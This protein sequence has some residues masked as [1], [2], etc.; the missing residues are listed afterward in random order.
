MKGLDV[1]VGGLEG[2]LSLSHRELEAGVHSDV[3]AVVVDFDLGR[4]VLAGHQHR[5][6]LHVVAQG[7][8]GGGVAHTDLGHRGL[9]V[10]PLAGRPVQ[11]RSRRVVPQVLA[12]SRRVMHHIDAKALQVVGRPDT[13]EHQQ[14]G[15]RHGAAANDD[16]VTLDREH[17]AAALG[18][19]P[20][21]PLALEQHPV[22]GDASPDGEVEAV[23]GGVQVVQGVAH[24]HAVDGVAGAGRHSG[25]I[26]V[27][28]VF[29]DGVA[30]GHAGLLEGDCVGQPFRAGVAPH[31]D[32]PVVAVEVAAAEVE[33]GLHLVEIGQT[34]G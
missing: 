28:L 18:F 34:A 11:H 15:R 33:V 26:G 32:G 3:V 24:A 19:H 27:V 14:L 4:A 12:H 22:S 29:V 20:D 21:G 31:R 2:Q 30:L 25:G 16:L 6:E 8:V 10:G 17:L 23:A 1:R 9:H 5:L 7:G 13:G